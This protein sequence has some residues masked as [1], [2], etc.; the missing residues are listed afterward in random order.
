MR[1]MVD[2]IGDRKGADLIEDVT[3]MAILKAVKRDELVGIYHL[4][5]GGEV[6]WHGYASHV[7]KF[8]KANGEAL[9]V[10]AVNPIETTAYP[11]PACRPLNSR[12]NTQ[13]LRE[14]FCLHLPDWQS[15]VNRMLREVLNK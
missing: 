8:A 1:V 10:T 6:S 3:A 2:K 9:A 7:I 5:S 11:T 4:A 15:G 13:K 12:L 14:K